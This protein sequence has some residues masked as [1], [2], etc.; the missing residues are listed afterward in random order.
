[1]TSYQWRYSSSSSEGIEAAA[2]DD[3]EGRDDC[4]DFF[5]LDF[6]AEDLDD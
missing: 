4:E 2:G 6:F 3:P 1:M 5:D